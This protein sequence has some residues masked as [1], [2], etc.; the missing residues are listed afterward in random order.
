MNRLLLLLTLMGPLALTGCL[1]VNAQAPERIS[2]GDRDIYSAAPSADIRPADRGNAADL[3]RENAQ[4]R[5]RVNYL[6]GRIRKSA[7]KYED[8]ARD[9]DKVRG[10]MDQ[11]AR[12]RDR[13]KQALTR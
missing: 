4:L 2:L 13:Y 12:E 7:N 9:M 8:Q 1:K 10:D 3:Q 6:D 5:E 11:L